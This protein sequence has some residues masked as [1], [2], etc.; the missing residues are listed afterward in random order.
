[1]QLDGQTAMRHYTRIRLLQRRYWLH[2]LS[3]NYILIYKFRCSTR[4]DYFYCRHCRDGISSFWGIDKP[5]GRDCVRL[6]KIE[7]PFQLLTI[8]LQSPGM[9][10]NAYFAFQ[11]LFQ[12]KTRI[13]LDANCCRLL[14]SM[15]VVPFL[16][17]LLSLLSLSKGLFLSFLP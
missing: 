8:Y 11:V 9:G 13:Q 14:G 5:P 12:N 17:V 7:R 3:I 2:V 16:T 15:A 1:M 10:L 4:L 6:L